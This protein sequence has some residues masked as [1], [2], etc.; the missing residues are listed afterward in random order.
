VAAAGGE[1]LFIAERQ[2][3]TFGDIQGVPLV[4]GYEKLTL[5]EMALSA[6][7]AYLKSFYDDLRK[8]RFALIVAPQ[9]GF[10]SDSLEQFSDEDSR[11][12][13]RVDAYLQCEYTREA[14]LP[15]AGVEILVPRKGARA[16]P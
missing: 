3:L 5:N 7:Q 10:A 2:L 4:P 8:H 9:H 12:F 13:E 11:W 16:C 15:A 1:V 6:N 14:A